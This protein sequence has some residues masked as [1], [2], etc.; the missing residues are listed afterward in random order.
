MAAPKVDA[1]KQISRYSELADGPLYKEGGAMKSSGNLTESG[2]IATGKMF[3]GAAVYRQ[4]FSGTR[5]ADSSASVSVE[6]LAAAEGVAAVVG[7]VGHLT[8]ASTNK[9]C[10]LGSKNDGTNIQTSSI[11]VT[12]AGAMN[13]VTNGVLV[14]VNELTGW[15]IV[16]EYT[17]A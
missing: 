9:A 17:K 15:D 16:I 12:A 10:I 13:L 8:L 14:A 7:A 1:G 3:G 5:T 11:E 6:L 4:A 2:E